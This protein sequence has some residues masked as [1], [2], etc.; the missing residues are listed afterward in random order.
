LRP[1][2]QMMTRAR[3]EA[4]KALEL[5]DVDPSAHAVLGAIAGSYEYDWNQ[6]KE[7]F[8][9]AMAVEPVEPAIR[10]LFTL[11]YLLPLGAF[12]AARQ[13]QEKAIEQDP[14]NL[15]WRERLLT[16]VQLSGM[17]EQAISGA[18]KVLDFDDK[19]YL[20]HYT[21]AQSYLA[22]GRLSDACI[23]AG[24]AYRLAPWNPSA[25]GLF[26]GLL[27]TAGDRG[28]AAVLIDDIA[29]VNSVVGMLAY[30]VASSQIDAAIESYR[31]AIEQRHP[32]AA[33]SIAA[34]FLAPF[35]S[36]PRWRD[37]TRMMNLPAQ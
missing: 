3:A 17:Y 14:L 5:Q 37:L 35:R 30:Y 9:L 34:P 19:S 6:A 20:A 10:E 23:A 2:P 1:L 7:Q 28:N 11:S 13:Q 18:Q 12:E 8:R 4:L 22:L 29:R 26:A 33:E 24:K 27:E 21:I 15:L 31:E 25:M 32:F 36:N 16:V